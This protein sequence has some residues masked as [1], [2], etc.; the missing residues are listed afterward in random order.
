MLRKKI[1]KN[2]AEN[3]IFPN[4]IIRD[5]TINS[6]GCKVTRRQNS[7]PIKDA[8]VRPLKKQKVWNPRWTN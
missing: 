1:L 4:Y 7:A 2:L 8:R 6:Y 5:G 3:Y